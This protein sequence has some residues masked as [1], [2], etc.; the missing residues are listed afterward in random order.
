MGVKYGWIIYLQ[1]QAA[2]WPDQD[3][4]LGMVLFADLQ[5]LYVRAQMRCVLVYITVIRTHRPPFRNPV[6][7]PAFKLA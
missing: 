2:D 5:T 7:A 6:S 4:D 1:L 3:A